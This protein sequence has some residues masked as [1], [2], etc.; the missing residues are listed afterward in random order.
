[1]RKMLFLIMVLCFL[2]NVSLYA[3]TMPAIDSCRV[4][5]N[6]GSASKADSNVTN[7]LKLSVRS[8]YKAYKSWIKFDISSLDVGSMADC[9]LRVTLN[10]SRSGTNSFMV[11]AV[12]DDWFKYPLA[13]PTPPIYNSPIAP[14]GK[15]DSDE[16]N[17]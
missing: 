2:C 8:D 9:K 1:M 13:K 3:G 11:S 16:S 14:T 10:A 12:N 6:S 7:S 4:N 15:I 17:T 5:L